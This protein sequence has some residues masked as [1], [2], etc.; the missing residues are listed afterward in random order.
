MKDLV[1]VLRGHIRN[2]FDTNILYDFVTDLS[3]SFNLKIFI[4]TW[5]IKATSLSWR[6]IS[7]DNTEI[8]EDFLKEYFKELY[9]HVQHVI[10]E[11]DKQVELIG[12]TEGMTAKTKTPI[13]GWKRYIYGQ[14]K[15]LEHVR[16]TLGDERV[17]N[18]RFDLFSNSYVFP[19]DDVKQFVLDAYNIHSNKNLFL[20]PGKYCGVDNIIIGSVHTMF[21]LVNYLHTNADALIQANPDVVHPEF[22]FYIANEVM[23]NP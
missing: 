23:E 6:K 1:L 17:V 15:I 4:H 14:Y 11:D 22:F 5:A 21:Y 12:N 10:I 16:N 7:Q 20:K 19:Y 18:T 8:T 2:S 9:K 13:I 3:A